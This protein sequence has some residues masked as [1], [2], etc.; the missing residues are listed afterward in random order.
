MDK[1]RP[2]VSSAWPSDRAVNTW[3]AN[4]SEFLPWAL[5]TIF[6]V[7]DYK[8]PSTSQKGLF[9][10]PETGSPEYLGR[11]LRESARFGLKRGQALRTIVHQC[12]TLPLVSALGLAARRLFRVWTT[13]LRGPGPHEAVGG[14]RV[15]NG[16]SN[17][18]AAQPHHS[19]TDGGQARPRVLGAAWNTAALPELGR[20]RARSLEAAPMVACG[21]GGGRI[22]GAARHP[23][24]APRT[25]PGTDRLHVLLAER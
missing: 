17:R 6:M 3:R 1:R 22:D 10:P 2:H 13:C 23:E 4:L 14:S 24:R 12:P 20:R 7:K 8:H 21:V 16:S 5:D 25:A 11:G 9:A 19:G 15:R 18:G